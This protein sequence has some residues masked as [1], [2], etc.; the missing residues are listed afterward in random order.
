MGVLQK[1][2]LDMPGAKELCTCNPYLKRTEVIGLQKRKPDKPI[3]A[4]DK[5]HR[6]NTI[7]FS[8]P[9]SNKRI[10]RSQ[11]ATPS[12]IIEEASSS[13]RE[14]T[15]PSP[16]VGSLLLKNLNSMRSCGI[17]S[18][19]HIHLPSLVQDGHHVRLSE[20]SVYPS[21]LVGQASCPSN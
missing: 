6:S 21:K 12:T 14:V 20:S 3:G 17:L 7:N 4:N 19:F 18:N 8:C 9:H 15:T 1:T 2:L 11:I 13:M 5:T 10:T 16:S